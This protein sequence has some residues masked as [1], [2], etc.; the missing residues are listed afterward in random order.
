MEW[1]QVVG[2]YHVAKLKSFTQ[3]AEATYRTQSALTQQIRSLEEELDCQLFERIGKRKIN[4]TPLGERFFRFSESLLQ[5]YDRLIGD[6]GEHKCLNKG[7]LKV[8]APFTTLYHLLPDVIRTYNHQFPW[9]EL[10]LFDRS[11]R[12]VIEL[13]K[14]GDI[15]L[16]LALE[17]IIP[18]ELNKRRWK[19]VEPVLLTSLAHPLT[20][21]KKV[22]LESIAKYPLILPPKSSD[23]PHR[24]RLEELFR[25]HNLNYSVIME[26]SNVELS[27][28]YVEMGLGV[29]FASIV[30]ELP[31]FKK[32]KI[33]FVLLNHYL[34][35]EHIC[36]VTRRDKKMYSFQDAFL[37]ML[38]R[39][40]SIPLEATYC[41]E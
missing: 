33:E 4:L 11:Q 22:S 17:T 16:G 1:Q 38:F 3:A 39:K 9:V 8:A 18:K 28:L 37:T 36:V 6:I 34:T 14:G 12:D 15:D 20:R 32:R 40:P 35:A 7:R 31:V 41:P 30:R 27:S 25:E 24:R 2:F 26:S 19:K 29:S 21:E 5:E 23:I 13:V 10:S